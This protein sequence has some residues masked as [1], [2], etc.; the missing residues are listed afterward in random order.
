MTRPKQISNIQSNCRSFAAVLTIV[1]ALAFAVTPA[2]QAQTYTVIHNFT[3]T[4]GGYPDA[5]LT[6]D[7]GGNFYGTA[8]GGGTYGRGTVFKLSHI[9]SGWTVAP[10]Y[11]FAGDGDGANPLAPVTIGPDGSLF[12]T[13]IGGADGTGTLFNLKPPPTRPPSVVSPW[14]LTVLHTFT[15]GYDG[16]QPVYGRLI[17]DAEG[18]LYGTTWFGGSGSFGIAYEET[19][20]ANG[21]T[22]NILYDF[23]LPTNGP[24]AGVVRDS[25]GNLFGTT[26]DGSAVFEL[27]PSGSGWVLNILHT[28][29]GQDGSL[30]YGGLVMDPAGNLYGASSRGGAGGDYGGVVYQ[31]SPYGD[32]FAFNVI[33][34]LPG[35]V[36]PRGDMTLDAAGNLY[37][38][39]NGDGVN[40]AGMVFK[41]TPSNGSW[42]LTDLHDFNFDTEYFPYGNVTIDANGNLWGTTSQGGAY[43]KGV[44]W[45][46]TP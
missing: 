29:T 45:E 22:E 37:G 41:L 31:L 10:L 43:S 5:G 23:S 26:G 16:D 36:G 18:N 44:I 39:G 15:G 9:G 27:S 3:G 46:I 2:V 20:S 40:S 11:S 35:A 13:T 21:W 28:F 24:L 12:G 17:F 42:T 38:L 19:P 4:E 30:A 32:T 7:K 14:K 6:L 1:F 25:S 34:N 8:S 33:Y